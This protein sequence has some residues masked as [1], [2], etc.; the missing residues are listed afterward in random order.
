MSEPDVLNINVAELAQA[1]DTAHAKGVEK[2]AIDSAVTKYDDAVKAQQ[3][4]HRV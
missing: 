3:V 1:I 4:R 2:S